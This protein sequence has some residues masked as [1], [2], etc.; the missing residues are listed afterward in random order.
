MPV[1]TDSYSTQH[2]Q[3]ADISTVLG[4]FQFAIF[5]ET[6]FSSLVL[7]CPNIT[8]PNHK[9]LQLLTEFELLEENWDLEGAVKPSL[10]VIDNARYI[11]QLFGKHGQQVFHAAPGPNG[12]IMLDIRN[13][14]KSKSFEI[15][16][17]DDRSVAVKFPE[18]GHPEQICFSTETLPD[19]LHWLSS[20]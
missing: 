2:L 11:T 9:I 14:S 6:S 8:F 18:E 5:D 10:K 15:I 12:E 1:L 3:H 7:S 16:F 19:L 17:Y 4:N 20:K 13:K